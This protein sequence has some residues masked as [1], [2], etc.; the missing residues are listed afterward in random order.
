MPT[1]SNGGTT[2]TG[3]YAPRGDNLATMGT[4]LT[5]AAPCTAYPRDITSAAAIPGYGAGLY[6]QGHRTGGPEPRD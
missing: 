4:Q 3:R 6:W 2:M 1:P 5:P